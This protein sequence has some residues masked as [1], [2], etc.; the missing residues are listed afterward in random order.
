M[1]S[2]LPVTCVNEHLAAHIHTHTHTHT[3]KKNQG[4]SLLYK[5]LAKNTELGTHLCFSRVVVDL[6]LTI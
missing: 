4:D 1:M 5:L 2:E 3:Q 6:I